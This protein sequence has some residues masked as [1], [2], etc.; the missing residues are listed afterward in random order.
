[1]I[2]IGICDD[3]QKCRDLLQRYC[4]KIEADLGQDFKYEMFSSGEEVLVCDDRIEI[5]LLDI[6]MSGENGID[7]M[8]KI[9]KN[10]NIKNILFVSGYSQRVYDSFGLK[11]RGFICKP[12]EYSRFEFEIKKILEMKKSDDEVFE[13]VEKSG[14]TYVSGEDIILIEVY[15]KTLKI[16]TVDRTY[17]IRGSLNEWKSRL[18]RHNVIQVHRSYLVNLSHI[19]KI[20]DEVTLKDVD[21]HVPVGRKYRDT[22]RTAYKEYIF[23]NFRERVNDR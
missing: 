4:E 11:T 22:S 7:I 10:D 2:T 9:E 12:I 15:G 13:L 8:R 16:Y 19:S 5:L 14:S 21:I 18:E 6:E 1:M 23:K 20:K 3:E 17:F